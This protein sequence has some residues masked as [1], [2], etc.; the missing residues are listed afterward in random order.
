MNQETILCSLCGAVMPV[1]ESFPV[2]D[3]IL[4]AD[5]RQTHTVACS[6]CGGDLFRTNNWG[7]TDYPL[8]E[9][10]FD[11][12]YVRCHEC[13]RIIPAEDAERNGDEYDYCNHCYSRFFRN[14]ICD[15]SY[16]PD[17]IFYGDGDRFFGVELEIDYGGEYDDSAEKILEVCNRKNEHIY[18]KHDGSLEEGMEIVTHPMTLAYHMNEMDWPGIAGTALALDYRS[19]QTSTCGLHVHVNRSS[20]SE[21]RDEQERIVGNILYLV[22]KFWDKLL[23][24]SRRTQE[25]LDR[26]ASRYGYKNRPKDI[27]KGAKESYPGRYK[28]VN[29]QN[30]ATIEFRIFR[31]TLK[32]NTILATLQMVNEICNAAVFLSEEELCDLTWGHF[33]NRLRGNG[34][35]MAYLAERELLTGNEEVAD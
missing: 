30:D 3:R 5:C 32:V 7:S 11:G 18:I 17:P 12:Y 31:G 26:W 23:R 24:F 27:Y 20:L 25:Q 2:G 35:L 6:H 4:C 13:G 9:A 21:D 33:L 15:Y 8:C 19:H 14:S 22:E 16:K 29:I 10:C 28:C 34:E 1:A